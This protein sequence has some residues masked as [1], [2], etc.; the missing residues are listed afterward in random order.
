MG[1]ILFWDFWHSTG[2]WVWY[3]MLSLNANWS[4]EGIRIVKPKL[5][6][7]LFFFCGGFEYL[8]KH[9]LL[10]KHMATMCLREFTDRDQDQSFTNQIQNL[11]S[12]RLEQSCPDLSWS[13]C[14]RRIKYDYV[15]ADNI[16]SSWISIIGWGSLVRPGFCKLRPTIWCS[17]PKWWSCVGLRAHWDSGQCNIP[18]L[19]EGSAQ[20]TQVSAGGDHTVLLRSDGRVVACGTNHHGQCNILRLDTGGFH[21]QWLRIFA[22]LDTPHNCKLDG[23]HDV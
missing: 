9:H 23:E 10:E 8:E 15:F 1:H 19:D 18:P 17:S 11:G 5:T 13:F 3:W 20:C 22:A 6:L 21:Q 7:L 12:S 14:N 2:D 16:W 4:E